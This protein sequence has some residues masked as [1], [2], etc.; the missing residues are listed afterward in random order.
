MNEVFLTKDGSHSVLS[1][2]FQ[3]AYHSHNGAIQESNH[4]FINAG[5]N[6][7]TADQAIQILEIGFGTGL[8]ALLTAIATIDRSAPITY[9]ALEKFPLSNLTIDALN[10]VELL[11][12][13]K[14][15]FEKMHQAKWAEATKIHSQFELIKLEMDFL[16]L[17]DNEKYDLIYLDAFAPSAQPELWTT[18]ALSIFIKSLKPG[19]TLTTYCA[20]G[21]VRRSF[22]ELDCAAE[23]LP[24]P[25]G[26]REMLRITRNV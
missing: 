19:G 16:T 10:Y 26:K 5:L 15:L 24:G 17:E 7:I 14:E 23:R 1:E 2:K 13:G 22:I 4:V 3:V 20:K 21:V 9:T 11:G 25:P 8:N 18:E 12:S 6:H